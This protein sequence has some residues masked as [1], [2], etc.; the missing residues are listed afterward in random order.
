[1]QDLTLNSRQPYGILE[2]KLEL[3]LDSNRKSKKFKNI[4]LVA[5]ITVVIYLMKTTKIG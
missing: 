5:F 1:M 4:L 3:I 2:L